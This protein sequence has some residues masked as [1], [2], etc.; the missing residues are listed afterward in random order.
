MTV[1]EIPKS[2]V[3]HLNYEEITNT[4]S[5]LPNHSSFSPSVTLE[6]SRIGAI[7]GVAKTGS[8]KE[9][10]N[11]FIS[12]CPIDD[13]TKV[14]DSA[15]K[16]E[17]L[18]AQLEELKL[19]LDDETE[20]EEEANNKKRR[21]LRNDITGLK[22]QHSQ[23]PTAIGTTFPFEGQKERNVFKRNIGKEMLASLEDSW[24]SLRNK[25]ENK[26]RFYARAVLLS[27][28]ILF[29]FSTKFSLNGVLY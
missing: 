27:L 2:S 4:F 21:K 28:K 6:N 5:F 14:V 9:L 1:S 22:M 13:H 18:Q 3:T 25:H 12:C 23:N 29:F 17:E 20:E 15:A 19:H 26:V 16:I 24:K 7:V 10:E 8:D 11:L